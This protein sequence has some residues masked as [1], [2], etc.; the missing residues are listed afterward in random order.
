MLL[1]L[2]L[3][4]CGTGDDFTRP[5]TWNPTNANAANLAAMLA[6]PG[7]AR[8]GVAAPTERGQ[9]GSQAIRRLETGRRP[10]LPDSRAASIGQVGGAAPVPEPSNER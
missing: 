5:G 2:A 4:G 8:R 1:M 3:G 7:H 6:E 9:L 10:P